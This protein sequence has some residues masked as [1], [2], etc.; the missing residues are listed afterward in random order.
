[1]RVDLPE[2]VGAL[3][4][5]QKPGSRTAARTSS[6]ILSIGN[7][8]VCYHGKGCGVKGVQR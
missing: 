7:T 1:M 2:P 5:T 4:R 3:N 6:R 8:R